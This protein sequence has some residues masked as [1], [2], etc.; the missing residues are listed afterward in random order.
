MRWFGMTW[1]VDVVDVWFRMPYTAEGLV[2]E[3]RLVLC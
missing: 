3:G 1:L 2:D